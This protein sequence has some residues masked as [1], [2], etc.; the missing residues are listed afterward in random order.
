M[1]RGEEICNLEICKRHERTYRS[2]L[3]DVINFQLEISNYKSK[4]SVSPLGADQRQELFARFVLLA[5]AAE[6]G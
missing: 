2:A 5:E 3:A 4:V 1:T 6:H